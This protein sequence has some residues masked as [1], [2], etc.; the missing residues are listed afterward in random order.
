MTLERNLIDAPVNA[1]IITTL[2]DESMMRAL[3]QFNMTLT[4]QNSVN[5]PAANRIFYHPFVLKGPFYTGKMVWLN[6]SAVGGDVEMGVY[7]HSGLL[8]CRT[9]TVA[10]ASANVPQSAA[11]TVPMWL[12]P[13]RYYWGLTMSTTT[14][15]RI[16]SF[17]AITLIIPFT[18]ASGSLQESSDPGSFGLVSQAT[19]AQNTSTVAFGT[20]RI[21]LIGMIEDT[22][23]SY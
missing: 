17:G 15:S 2:S 6:G 10:Q 3:S 4:F 12:P 14:N 21:H 11:P 22:T 20:T 9:G 7:S 5:W 13:G 23:L 16:E 8:L 1:N 19:F 18:R